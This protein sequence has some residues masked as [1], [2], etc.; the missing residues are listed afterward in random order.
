MEATEV[1]NNNDPSSVSNMEATAS[2]APPT[3]DTEGEEDTSD[4]K[5]ILVTIPVDLWQMVAAKADDDETSVPGWVRQ[6]IA[7]EFEYTLPAITIRR[8][9]AT[10]DERKEAQK[11]AASQRNKLA[12]GLLKALRE[13]KIDLASL[14][15]DL[16]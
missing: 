10:E 7:G 11:Q 6:L 3:D 14:G 5:T 12:A 4:R 16:D 13:G 9:Y 15:I 1:N 2:D 8:K